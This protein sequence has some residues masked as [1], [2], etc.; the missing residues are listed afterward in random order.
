VIALFR[1]FPRLELA[2]P[3]VALADLPTPVQKLERLGEVMGHPEL[4]I[5][6]D[7]LSGK[8]Y[9]GNK[10]RKLEFLLGE[11]L[12]KGAKEVMTF[13][14]AGS[15]HA[16][17]TAIYAQ[18][19]GL[20]SISMLLPQPNARSVRR[21]LL[22]SYRH[23]AELHVYDDRRKL[24]R[25]VARELLR[26]ALR[27][28]KVPYVIPPGGSSPLG[29]VGYVNAAFELAEQIARGQLPEPDV[30]YVAAGTTGT[31]VGLMVGLKAA[32]LKTLVALIRVTGEQFVNIPKTLELLSRTGTLLHQADTLFPALPFRAADIVLRHDFYGQ[33]YALYTEQSVDAMRLLK[34]IE[35]I[36]LEGTY[37][38]KA[39][40]ALI[41]DVRQASLGDKVVLFWNTY[42]SRDFSD[43][44]AGMDYHDLPQACHRYFEED[45]QPLDRIE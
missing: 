3:R 43:L 8:A 45:V 32:G 11:A 1:A 12:R 22:M 21:N 34:R 39:C 35:G 23:G 41:H 10:V 27:T 44:I 17:A 33:E 13:G 29:A 31:S 19:L 18:H 9:G 26:H 30:L 24:S 5:K 28:G 42:N 16:T 25:G 36:S 4:Y 6:R 37:T 38:G 2:L 7:D 14:C 20:R 15:N 40:A